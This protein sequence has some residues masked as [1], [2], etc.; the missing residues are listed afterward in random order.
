MDDSYYMKKALENAGIAFNIGE[1]PV[2]AVIVKDGEIISSG[3]NERE[4]GKSATAHA[5]LLAIERACKK[6][7]SWRL[8]GCTL[9]V[10]LE[11]CPMCSGA[12]INS[13]I[14]RVVCALKDPKAGALGSVLDMNSY[15]FNHKCRVEF[16]L[17]EKNARQ[18]L[19]DFFNLLRSKR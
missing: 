4:T 1:I 9:Y 8:H 2:G 18:L 19:Q 15:P 16:G 11:P 7:G 12:I 5:E 10:T 6:L 3:Y 13:R 14:E 17:M